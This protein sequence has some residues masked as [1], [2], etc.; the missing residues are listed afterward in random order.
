MK[1]FR[2]GRLQKPNESLNFARMFLNNANISSLGYL[3]VVECVACMRQPL[4]V[5]CK[6]KNNYSYNRQG[7]TTGP[8]D[9]R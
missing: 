5:E 4:F 9:D 7:T 3:I 8:C 1:S 2:F 6:N